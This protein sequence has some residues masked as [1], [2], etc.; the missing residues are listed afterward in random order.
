MTSIHTKTVL[1]FKPHYSAL[2]IPP[3]ELTRDSIPVGYQDQLKALRKKR[4]LSQAQLAELI[5]VEQPTVQ[6]WES[7]KRVPDLDN[8]QALARALGTT[9][10]AILDGDSVVSIGPTLFIKGE[11]AAGVWLPAAEWP[12]DAW[13][14]FTGRSDVTAR[15]EHRFGLRVTGDS[16]DLLYPHGSIVECVSTFGNAEALPGRRVIIVRKND[17]QEYEATVKELVEQQGELW[18]VPRSTNP[19]HRPFKLNE[20]EEG[21]LETRIVAVVV[22]SIR[23]E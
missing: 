18:A 1:W 19:A 5:G 21:I 12:E 6:R 9:P 23:P 14:T 8:L 17:R 20:S 4:Q 13:Q 3:A 2:G 7:G 15:M 11:V 22:A 16:M 10:G